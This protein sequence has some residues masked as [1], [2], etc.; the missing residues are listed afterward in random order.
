[1]FVD[2]EDKPVLQSEMKLMG[3][4]S[5]RTNLMDMANANN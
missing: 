4:Q 3:Q 5:A 2:G 1:M